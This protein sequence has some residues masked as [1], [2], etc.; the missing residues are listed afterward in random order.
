MPKAANR[1]SGSSSSRSSQQ[2]AASQ[3][4]A[5]PQCACA[6]PFRSS[7][8]CIVVEAKFAL[9][10]LLFGSG[11]G[12]LQSATRDTLKFAYKASAGVKNDGSILMMSKDP[13]TDPGKKSKEGTEK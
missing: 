3:C 12:L 11:G 9:G 10:N 1:R 6:T 13:V 7:Q 4:A 2:P 5:A 8:A